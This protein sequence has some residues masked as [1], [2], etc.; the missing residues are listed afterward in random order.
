MSAEA[1]RRES[2]NAGSGTA[3]KKSPAGSRAFI[4]EMTSLC[5]FKDFTDIL[6]LV[7]DSTFQRPVVS[8]E[9]AYFCIA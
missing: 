1:S 5:N 4:K 2:R 8:G 7:S 3:T 6:Q 9:Q